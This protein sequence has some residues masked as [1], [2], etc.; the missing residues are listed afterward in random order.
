MASSQEITMESAK[1]LN[2]QENLS[3]IK[4]HAIQK[5]ENLEEKEK[6]R[7]D[8]GGSLEDELS[9][10]R[11]EYTPVI[12]KI[13]IDE[14]IDTQFPDPLSK[15]FR[16]RNKLDDKEKA[17][18][19]AELLEEFE[20]EAAQIGSGAYI[21][22]YIE[23][24]II[25]PEDMETSLAS[26]PENI[27]EDTEATDEELDVAETQL[28]TGY[29]DSY[30]EKE[31][32]VDD[33]DDYTTVGISGEEIMVDDCT[34]PLPDMII[35]TPIE[36]TELIEEETKIATDKEEKEDEKVEEEREKPE[37]LGPVLLAEGDPAKDQSELTRIEILEGV[38]VPEVHPISKRNFMF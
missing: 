27:E 6:T 36:G 8:K 37:I 25:E 24:I 1:D 35:T 32:Y 13:E 12:P 30:V 11:T 2:T 29:E 20:A 7:E 3:S 14:A 10:K 18:S 21:P 4:S 28:E 16:E 38:L 19:V 22:E 5:G 34:E 31:E 33:S 23:D 17:K 15:A 9:D 26:S